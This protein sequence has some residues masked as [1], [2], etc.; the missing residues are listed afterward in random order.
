MS[1]QADTYEEWRVTGKPGAGYPPYSFTWSRR[2]QPNASTEPEAAAR[3]FLRMLA[4]QHVPPWEDGPHMH[5]RTVVI[6]EWEAR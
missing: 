4:D 1:E 6:G 2:L 3:A 5:R